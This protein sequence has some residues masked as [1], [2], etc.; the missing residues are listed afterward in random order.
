[1]IQA[2]NPDV[3]AALV[4]ELEGFPVT[5]V[6]GECAWWEFEGSNRFRGE[7]W[8]QGEGHMTVNKKSLSLES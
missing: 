1:M 2:R 5:P 8:Q 3:A 4:N 7:P 6:L